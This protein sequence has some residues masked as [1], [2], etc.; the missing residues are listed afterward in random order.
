MA[1]G[2]RSPTAANALAG[3]IA[4]SLDLVKSRKAKMQSQICHPPAEMQNR[5]HKSAVALE[6]HR[7]C[8]SLLLGVDANDANIDDVSDT[9]CVERMLDEFFVSDL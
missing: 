9:H 8:Y 2:C 7:K 6:N 1:N 5:S 4:G 3:N